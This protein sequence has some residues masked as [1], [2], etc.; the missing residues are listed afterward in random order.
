ML[1]ANQRLRVRQGACKLV[2]RSLKGPGVILAR[3]NTEIA[4]HDV[5]GKYKLTGGF[6]K[7]NLAREMN[8][9]PLEVNKYIK[10]AI[11]QTVYKGELLAFKKNLFGSTQIIAP[12]DAI[13]ENVDRETGEITLKMIPKEVALTSGVFGVVESVDANR[14]E[15]T[16]KC[17]TT[18]LYGI[19]GTGSEREGFL[20]IIAGSGDLVNASKIN[21]SNKGQILVAGSL[22]MQETIKKALTCNVSG[23]ICGG[24]NMDDYLSMATSLVPSKRVGTE[25]GI[26]LVAS[27]GFGLIP[28]GDDFQEI[29]AGHNEKFAMISGNLGRVLLPSSDPDSILSCR[30]VSLPER[31]AQG[32]KPELL[33]SEL[34]NGVKVRLI[35]PPF[36]GTQG[37]VS[38]ID[39]TPTTLESGISTYLVTVETKSRKIKVPY[40]NIEIII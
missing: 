22:V 15:V 26:S 25:I 37:K 33:V 27:E 11:G 5:L 19:F 20:N 8:I 24:L 23:I 1:Y 28:I 13:F 17:L 7:L 36:M 10:K 40:G 38:D 39:K 34:K 30:K 6:T 2:K 21:L 12:T 4:P 3:K 9:P 35:W 29:L 31:Q 14:G 16:I 18:E 32:V